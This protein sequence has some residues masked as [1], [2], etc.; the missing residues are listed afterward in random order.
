MRMS[1]Q[2]KKSEDARV[3]QIIDVLGSFDCV[4]SF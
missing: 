4:G 1:K 2:K 3:S